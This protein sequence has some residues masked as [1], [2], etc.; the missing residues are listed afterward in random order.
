M[1]FCAY[2]IN[3]KLQL[4]KAMRKK[5]GVVVNAM[6]IDPSKDYSSSA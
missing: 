2:I 6:N 1:A 4:C 5:I 3:N